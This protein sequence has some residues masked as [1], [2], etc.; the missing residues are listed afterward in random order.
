MEEFK[1]II[2]MLLDFHIEQLN[3]IGT[4]KESSTV[5]LKRCQYTID[6]LG[7]FNSQIS[8]A[9]EIHFGDRELADVEKNIIKEAFGIFCFSGMPKIK[10][11]K[12]S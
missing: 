11:S 3:K 1:R 7:L 12:L 2:N 10:Y 8:N 9:I 5:A 6:Y 4:E